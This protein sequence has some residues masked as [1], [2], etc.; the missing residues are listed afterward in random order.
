MSVQ[1]KIGISGGIGSGKSF[2]C[3]LLEERGYPVYYAD[4]RA[5]FL[6]EN[7]KKVRK[8]L[9]E[10]FGKEAFLNNTLNKPYIASLIFTDNSKRSVINSIVHPAV[11]DDFDEWVKRQR[12][13]LVFQESALIFDTGAYKRFDAT[14]LVIAPQE[15]RVERIMERDNCSKDEA[16]ARIQSQGNPDQHMNLAKF[17]VINDEQ[18]DLNLQIEEILKNLQSTSS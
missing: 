5:K 10:A 8:Q 9:I 18:E 11:R 2:V 15:L 3:A 4:S 6:M 14:I 7:D 16:V 12:A 13:P 17:I 1:Q